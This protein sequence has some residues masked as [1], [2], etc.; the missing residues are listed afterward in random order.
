MGTGTTS[1]ELIASGLQFPEGPIWLRDGRIL[2]VEI[3]SGTLAAVSPDGTVERVATTGGGPNGAAVGPDGKVYVCNNGGFEWYELNG[4][5]VA[6]PTTGGLHRWA[7]PARRHRHRRGRGPLHRGR[8]PPAAGPQRHRVRRRRRLLLHRPRQVAGP[9]RRQG[10]RLLR[11]CR[12][13]VGDGDRL[14]PRPRQRHRPLARRPPPLRR[15]DDH[16]PAVDVGDRVARRVQAARE[17]G[18]PRHAPVQLR[19]L[20][21]AR[22]DGRRR[23]RQRLRRHAAH[24]RGHRRV[25]RRARS[26]TSTSCPSRIRSSRTCASAAT[27]TR[28]RTSRHRAAACSTR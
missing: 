9:G 22:L 27:A 8:R 24:G 4:I 13:L 3:K 28:P 2:L 6:R 16:R 26:S 19:R 23:R 21:T 10:R 1:M 18:R 14:R 20:P 12:R 7:H 5:V 25:A 15:R 17:P 11:R